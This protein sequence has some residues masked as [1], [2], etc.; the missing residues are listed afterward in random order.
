MV[1]Y[2][3]QLRLPV[4][5]LEGRLVILVRLNMRVIC[6]KAEVPAV[7]QDG[8]EDIGMLTSQRYWVWR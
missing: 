7:D 4:K 5:I 2:A 6:G 3:V 1:T 8:L